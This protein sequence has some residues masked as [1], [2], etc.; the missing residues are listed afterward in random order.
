MKSGFG[1]GSLALSLVL[2]VVVVLLRLVTPLRSILRRS[3]LAQLIL[4]FISLQLMSSS[5]LILLIVVF[6][7]GF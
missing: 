5:P 2:V 7:I 4:T 3:F 1:L 6:W